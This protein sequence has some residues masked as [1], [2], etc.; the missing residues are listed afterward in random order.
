M[1]YEL[2]L[3][4]DLSTVYPVFHISMLQKCMGD[5]SHITPTEDV[6]VTEDIT[7]E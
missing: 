7:Y 4:Q 6:E 2:E 3:P 5:A 1:A